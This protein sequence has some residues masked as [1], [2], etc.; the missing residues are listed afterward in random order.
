MNILAIDFGS[1]NIGLAW[2]DTNLGIVLP[3]GRIMNNE[4][5][6]MNLTSLIDKEKINKIVVGLPIGLDGKENANT[7]R[8]R[9]FADELKKN[10]DLPVEFFDERF[11]SQ[12][13][14]AMGDGVS[15]DEKSAMIILENYRQS[16]KIK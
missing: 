16:V 13:A 8:V 3:F 7:E 1:K 6:I 9:K 10:T 5:R 11:S 4:S 15:R 12:A 2:C 14:D